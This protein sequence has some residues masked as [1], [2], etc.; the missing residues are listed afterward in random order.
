MWNEF[1][2][3]E[4]DLRDDLMEFIGY[5]LGYWQCVYI[6]VGLIVLF[7]IMAFLMFRVLVTKLN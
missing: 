4:Y 7:R 6:F 3:D 1:K 2:N 5:K